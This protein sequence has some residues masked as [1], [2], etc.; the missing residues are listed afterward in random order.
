MGDQSFTFKHFTV[1]QQGCAMK[2]GTDGTLLGAWAK[3]N[4]DSPQRILDIG[5]GTGL[6]A[7]M[8]AQRFPESHVTAIDIDSDA[9]MQ[10]SQNVMLSPYSQRI[11]VLN[12]SLQQYA[13]ETVGTF[14]VI[15]CNP[16]FFSNSLP[17]P[18]T[19]K[20]IARHTITLTF[21]ELCIHAEHLLREDGAFSVIVPI[22]RKND[23]IHEAALARMF[24]QSACSIKTSPRK[25][26]K[27]VL[28]SFCKH[29]EYVED[30]IE[31]TITIGDAH[32]NQLT[33]PFYLEKLDN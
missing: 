14:D 15:V 22:E 21:R 19:R 3:S 7:L 23:I 4:T 32:Y 29:K 13:S 5:T 24:L 10:A 16:P 18:D 1:Y 28:L 33:S 9:C 12:S 27:R 26:P 20:T 8:M 17:C 2:V 11:Q 30:N 25:Q 6:I 31:C